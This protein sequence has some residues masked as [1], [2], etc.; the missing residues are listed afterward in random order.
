[1]G[2]AVGAR[3]TGAKVGAKVGAGLIGILVG[4]GT[5]A[6]VRTGFAVEGTAGSGVVGCTGILVGVG[7]GANVGVT[8]VG[9]VMDTGAMFGEAVSSGPHLPHVRRHSKHAPVI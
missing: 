5:G 6:T 8:M 2:F 7:I 4:S 3:I 1:M 9:I